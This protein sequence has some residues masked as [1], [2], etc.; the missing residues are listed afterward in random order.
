VRCATI[1][2]EN[3]EENRINVTISYKPTRN[4][5]QRGVAAVKIQPWLYCFPDF[6]ARS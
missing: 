3:N 6:N 1:R 2:S 5:A 4:S